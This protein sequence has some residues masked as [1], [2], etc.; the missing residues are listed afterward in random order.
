MEK[1]DLLQYIKCPITNLIF[2]EPVLAED[3]N[4]YELMSLKVHQEHSETSPVTGEKMGKII[5][6]AKNM[7]TMVTE[8]LKENPEYK[9]DQFLTKKPFYLFGND[10]ISALKNKNYEEITKYIDIILN[11][12][13][14]RE[15]L[16]EIVCKICPDNVIQYIIDNSID[17]DIYDK[18]I[19]KPLHVACKC[20]SPNVI[21]HLMNKKVNL[22]SE[23]I[24]GE[25]PLGYLMLYR[26]A[27]IYKQLIPEFI[28]LGV[29]LNMLNNNGFMVAH[30]II[31][32]GDLDLLKLFVTN[33]LNMTA[34]NKKVGNMSILQYAFKESPNDKLIEY[35]I[36]LNINL[37]ID[38]DPK[39]TC[40][41]L[42]YSNRYLE[43]KQKQYIILQYLTKILKKPNIINNFID[44]I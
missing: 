20:A 11:T 36:N 31:N 16:F 18:R 19:L 10:F 27:D 17:Y 9:K 25:I 26:T 22:E 39:T 13:I 15:T 40:E 38:V 5:L 35:L 37:D 33:G 4:F 21:M 12:D 32:K 2:S 3:G 8:F 34:I 30:Y 14:G 44:T 43:K 29:N 42:I 7:K 28:K 1:N 24:N 6:S 23:D 41:Q